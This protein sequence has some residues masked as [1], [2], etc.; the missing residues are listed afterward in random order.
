MN[1]LANVARAADRKQ[2]A[3]HAYRTAIEQA[4]ADG[5]TLAA[6][7]QAAGISRQNVHKLLRRYD[8]TKTP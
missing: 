7:A 5:H 6:I 8:D 3:Q 4:R 1:A 2:A